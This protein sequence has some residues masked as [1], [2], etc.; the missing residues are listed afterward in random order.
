MQKK[1]FWGVQLA[2]KANNLI[3]ISE[4]IVLNVSQPYRFPRPVMGIALLFTYTYIRT[5]ILLHHQLHIDQLAPK[6]DKDAT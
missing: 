5:Y 2:R 6:L 1:I 3:T 4:P